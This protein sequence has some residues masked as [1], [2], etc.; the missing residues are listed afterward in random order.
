MKKMLENLSFR[1]ENVCKITLFFHHL[2]EIA[3]KLMSIQTS[4][5]ISKVGQNL[6]RKLVFSQK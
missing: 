6:F 2:L 3:K 1:K 4:P 5:G